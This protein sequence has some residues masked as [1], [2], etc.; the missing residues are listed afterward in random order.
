MAMRQKVGGLLAVMLVASCSYSNGERQEAFPTVEH[1]LDGTVVYQEP[2]RDGSTAV[3]IIGT[4]F[5]AVF[6]AAVCVT[7]VVI[8]A[9][10]AGVIALTD[11][12]QKARMRQSLDEGVGQN[13]GGPYYL[14]G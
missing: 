4:P 10:A 12:P 3:A 13:C 6:K 1:R 5:Y 8:A 2:K 11:N 7:S 9:P 14:R